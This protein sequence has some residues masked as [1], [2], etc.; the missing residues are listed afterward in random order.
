MY[1]RDKDNSIV[2][3]V[4]FSQKTL[5]FNKQTILLVFCFGK[6]FSW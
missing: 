6:C 4:L 1:V 5:V 3:V 2:D